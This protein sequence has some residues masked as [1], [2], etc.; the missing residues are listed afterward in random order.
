MAAATHRNVKPQAT[1]L[2]SVTPATAP[3]IPVP[4]VQVPTVHFS[5]RS[6]QLK[7]AASKLK[8]LQCKDTCYLQFPHSNL[9]SP[10]HLK[11]LRP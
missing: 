3:V 7:S 9:Y 10:L 8:R 5:A 2:I 1:A 4:A 6:S 11:S